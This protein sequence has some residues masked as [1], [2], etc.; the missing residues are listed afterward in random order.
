M[1]FEYLPYDLKK[2]AMKQE[3]AGAFPPT[4]KKYVFY[5]IVKAV[6]YLHS[7][8]IL[9]RD[10]K[11]QNILVDTN[12]MI[13]IADFG[14]ARQY[15]V[16]IKK[17]TPEVVTVWYR[18]PE[19]LL[20]SPEYTTSVDTWSLGCILAEL[21]NNEPLFPGDSEIGELFRIFQALGTPSEETW[22]GVTKLRDYKDV[23]PKWKSQ[24][25]K[26]LCPKLDEEGLD[27]LEKMLVY[28]PVNRIS[29]KDALK[30]PYFKDV[31]C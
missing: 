23:F 18:A 13:K 21:Y 27:L 11:P 12:G 31:M 26:A 7:K 14:L 20:G 10:L 19:I 28:D 17:Y 30:H 6:A 25:V 3:E 2:Y 16:P 29:P 24:G 1:I 22:K 9:H 5:Q 8:R 15:S 4:A